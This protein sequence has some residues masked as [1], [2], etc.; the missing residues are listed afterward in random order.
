VLKEKGA[1]VTISESSDDRVEIAEIAGDILSLVAEDEVTMQDRRAPLRVE[2]A[3]LRPGFGNPKDNHY[4]PPEMLRRY[5][6]V[7]EGVKMYTTDH[8]P[9]EKSERTEVAVMEKVPS[10]FLDDGTPVGISAIFD[11]YFAEKTRNR[12]ATGKLGTLESS[13]L[14]EGRVQRGTVGGKEANIVQ[15]LVKGISVDWVTKAGAGGRALN[16][17]ENET[18]N[19]EVNDMKRG[20][21]A[22]AFDAAELYA[23]LARAMKLLAEE[24]EP[25]P[26]EVPTETP[27][28]E[29]AGEADVPE[30][31][32]LLMQALELLN[33][34]PEEETP[35]PEAEPEEAPEAETA[36]AQLSESAVADV[37]KKAK[38]PKSAKA[39][40]ASVRYADETALSEAIQAEADYIAE[41][42]KAGQPV[43]AH[44]SKPAERE[45][46]T[47]AER[48]SAKSAVNRKWLGT[49]AKKPSG[50]KEK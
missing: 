4:Y 29:P 25:E 20:K 43:V 44:G 3:L 36:E 32:S 14:G 38:L 11:P 33:E 18:G 5:A 17:T 15:E 9:G 22:E 35:E 34:E 13:I 27:A 37:L 26:E 42:T 31:R 45:V 12:A 50:G 41:L 19:Q 49:R 47:L 30:L 40:L 16:L 8:R 1:I 6:H 23:L 7:F 10:R 46:R 2:V 28:E 48:E 21:V 39:R 24:P